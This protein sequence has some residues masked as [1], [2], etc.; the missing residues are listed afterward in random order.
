VQRLKFLLKTATV[1]TLLLPAILATPLYA[2]TAAAKAAAAHKTTAR[3][4]T[5]HKAVIADLKDDALPPGEDDGS[6]TVN[7]VPFS[8]LSP[9]PNHPLLPALDYA[10]SLLTRLDKTITGYTCML[11]RRERIDGELSE[12]E[13]IRAKISPE[14]PG[15]PLRV[16]L[17]FQA[18]AKYLGREI[19]YVANERDGQM[20]VRRGGARFA[21]ITANIPPTSDA[22]MRSSRYPLTDIGVRKLASRLLEQG[23]REL[24]Y[25]ECTVEY[26]DNAKVNGRDCLHIRVVHPLERPHFTFHQADIYIDRKLKVPVRYTA[27]GWPEKAGG[28]PQL[29]E[30]YNYLN[31]RMNA[32]FTAADFSEDNPDYGFYKRT[33]GAVE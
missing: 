9:L 16:Y 23:T 31:I 1:A 6:V 7:K 14:K 2:Q 12:Y 25:E 20:L 15:E 27:Y 32:K 28:E 19:L 3:K 21:Y 10:R 26:Y 5:A 30:E 24:H 18:P 8:D 22:A 17:N 33:A 4:V 29:L 11:V 13:Y